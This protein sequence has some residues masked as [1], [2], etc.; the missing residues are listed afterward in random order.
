M[1][2]VQRQLVKWMDPLVDGIEANKEAFLSNERSIDMQVCGPILAAVPSEKLAV[3]VMHSAVN[4][5]LLGGVDG[6]RVTNVI[7]TIA[8]GVQAEVRARLATAAQH[9]AHHHLQPLRT[10]SLTT[11]PYR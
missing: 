10:T 11:A 9:T 8:E 7:G 3:I 4:A 5:A 1:R 2:P 6:V